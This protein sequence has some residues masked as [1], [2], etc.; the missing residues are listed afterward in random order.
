M[1]VHDY[2]TNVIKRRVLCYERLC[3]KCNVA[4]KLRN[5]VSIKTGGDCN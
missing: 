4:L 2:E 3:K 5:C 1:T